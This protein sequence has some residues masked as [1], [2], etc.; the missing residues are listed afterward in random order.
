MSVSGALEKPQ[1]SFYP[2]TDVNWGDKV[3][4]TCTIVTEISGGTFILKKIPG[5]FKMEKFSQNEAATFTFAAVDFDNKGTYFCEYQKKL[6]N[7]VIFYPQGN[8][9]E[10]S[11]TG[12]QFSPLSF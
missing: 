12:Q 2:A 7:Q 3:E 11:V 5:S 1:I 9:A 6:L 8:T 4:I 10:L